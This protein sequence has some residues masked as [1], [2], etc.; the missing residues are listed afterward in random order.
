MPALEIFAI[1]SKSQYQKIVAGEY[2]I[3]VP[4]G[5]QLINK[6]G[7]RNLYFNCDDIEAVKELTEGLDE[8]RISWQEVYG[9]DEVRG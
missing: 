8:S 2:G 1:L 5:V 7:S 4:S 6:A 9:M 3:V